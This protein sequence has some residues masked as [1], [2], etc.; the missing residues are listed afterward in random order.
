MIQLAF[1][2]MANSKNLLSFGSRQ[3]LIVSVIVICSDSSLNLVMNRFRL[4]KDAYLLNLG[5][6]KIFSNS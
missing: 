2:L 3:I 5:R 6:F 1:P 4:S